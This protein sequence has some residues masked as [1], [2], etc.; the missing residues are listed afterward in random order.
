M[1]YKLMHP[2]LQ[3]IGGD[4]PTARAA[5]AP[6]SP[7]N[8]GK[9][10]LLRRAVGVAAVILA[11]F[12]VVATGVVFSGRGLERHHQ[13]ESAPPDV[14]PALP[15]SN[16]KP[17][18]PPGAML[19]GQYRLTLEDSKSTYVDSSPSEWS[20]GPVDYVGYIQFSTQCTGRNCV[21]TSTAPSI[22]DSSPSEKTVETLVW[23][24]GKWSSRANPIPD[25]G[26]LD[27]S[28]TV[29]YSNGRSGFRGTT[30]DTI[31][32]G[33]HAGARLIAPV[34]LTPTLDPTNM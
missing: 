2:A 9:C 6:A 1:R 31:I 11:V 12:G 10:W 13:A 19:N 24:S 22:P 16:P 34:V 17:P 7:T 33:P 21:A 5:A 25:G 26:A 4:A 15:P 28:T 29:L 30:T 32:S 14:T 23:V 8:V 3:T 18:I 27:E 20:A